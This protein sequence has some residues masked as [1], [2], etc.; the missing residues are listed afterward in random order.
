MSWV[1]ATFALKKQIYNQLSM[2]AS[3]F[4]RQQKKNCK[5]IY[6]IHPS[7]FTRT[8]LFF[9]SRFTSKKFRKKIH[10][11]YEW[12][13][14]HEH[15]HPANVA[16]PEASKEYITKTFHV[17]KVNAKGKEQGRLIKFT[18]NSLLNIEP[19]TQQLRNE[20]LLNEIAE[21]RAPKRTPTII[22]H[23][24]EDTC[25]QP[26][27]GFLAKLR[28]NDADSESRTYLCGSLEERNDI[29]CELFA[30]GFGAD[31]FG[32]PNE[33]EIEMQSGTAKKKA[34]AIKLTCDSLFIIEKAKI[35]K[36]IA[37]SGVESITADPADKTLLWM[38]FKGD[39]RQH[40][41][42]CANAAVLYEALQTCIAVST[43]SDA[44]EE[45][46]EKD[47]LRGFE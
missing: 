31:A 6:I 39:V 23:F 5:A 30:R 42:H 43:A 20:R 15:I 19:K 17:I 22:L 7:S 28:Q 32:F 4:D 25:K 18:H 2:F 10:E 29:V 44:A 37:Y 38:L 45:L 40:K 21:V 35:K 36:E 8:V 11:I 33:F 1:R 27:V 13:A 3:I 26:S 41:V 14:L 12:E 9:A 24:G 16:L 34:R 46:E 47:E